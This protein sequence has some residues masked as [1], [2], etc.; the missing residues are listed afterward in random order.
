M[1][2]NITVQEVLAKMDMLDYQLRTALYDL[3]KL[4]ERIVDCLN[5]QETPPPTPTT[6]TLKDVY[7][8]LKKHKSSRHKLRTLCKENGIN[9]L[10]EFLKISPSGILDYKGIGPKTVYDVRVAIESLGVVWSD[11]R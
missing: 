6:A 7:N 1:A 9:T 10:E 8:A 4:R 11:V 3:N 2:K 5:P